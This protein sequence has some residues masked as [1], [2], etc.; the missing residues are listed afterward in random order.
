MLDL[1]PD[2]GGSWMDIPEEHQQEYWLESMKKR[3]KNGDLGS[4]CDTYGRMHW[5]RP[6]GTITRKSST[7]SCGRYVHPEQNRNITVREAAR[8]QSFPDAWEFEGPFIS[9]YEQNG[10]AVPPKLANAIAEQIKALIPIEQKGARQV[11]FD[12]IG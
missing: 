4:F 3:A 7:P 8:L 12:S 11:T 6:S 5:D 10:N 1:I 2:D 9:W